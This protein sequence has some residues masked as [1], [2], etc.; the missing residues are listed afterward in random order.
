MNTHNI[1]ILQSLVS[2]QRQAGICWDRRAP[3]C[4]GLESHL[5]RIR[6]QDRK[7]VSLRTV[8]TEVSK[9]GTS[10]A[11]SHGSRSDHGS[12]GGGQEPLVQNPKSPL[13]TQNQK[14]SSSALGAG[15]KDSSRVFPGTDHRS[16]LHSYCVVF[17]LLK[18]VREASKA[19]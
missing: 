9:S 5:Q 14:A 1:S 18:E 8:R 11:E 17:I 16:L 7:A 19:F 13:H 6:Q 15:T 2:G 12:T 4:P 3:G 10:R